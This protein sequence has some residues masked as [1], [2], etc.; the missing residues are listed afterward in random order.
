VLY[1]RPTACPDQQRRRYIDLL[2]PLEPRVLAAGDWRLA[3][4]LSH[5]LTHL[6]AFAT[7]SAGGLGAAVNG[8]AY[9]FQM[10]ASGGTYDPR[11]IT[12]NPI[13]GRSGRITVL[14][15]DNPGIALATGAKILFAGDGNALDIYDTRTHKRSSLNLKSSGGRAG[16]TVRSS[17]VF[18]TGDV[19]DASTGRLSST[20]SIEADGHMS[21]TAASVGNLALFAGGVE[22]DANSPAGVTETTLVDIYN[23][24]TGTWSSAQLS[25]ARFDI[26]ATSVGDL[27][28][29][30]GGVRGF[31]GE[32]DVVDIYNADSNSW[33]T[34]HL[35]QPREAAAA[36]TVGNLAIFAGGLSDLS[37][38]QLS[39]IVDVY[40]AATG[41]WFT[42]TLSAP[43]S[44]LA[45]TPVAGH[46]LFA[47]GSGPD[48][49]AV[50]IF[51]FVPG[52]TGSMS[53]KP[54]GAVNV[55][56]QSTGDAALPAGATVSLYASRDGTLAGATLLGTTTLPSGLDEQA[57]ISVS[58]QTSLT[59]VPKGRYHLIATA[60]DDTG[61]GP[62]VIVKQP[63]TF[64]VR[65]TATAHSHSA[66]RAHPFAVKAG[67]LHGWPV[68]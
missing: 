63:K 19:Y 14:S 51:T 17:A 47:D 55:T 62:V 5:T 39:D 33:S 68:T 7:G 48:P 40:D 35:S 56:V 23:A 15:H 66:S 25:Q 38:Q 11:A 43:R 41:Q 20:M 10:R 65:A 28:L 52:I 57:S 42:M 4:G 37:K 36:T 18:S 22:R 8:V 34:A 30:G 54:G 13:T 53:G 31:Q 27:A 64:T 9:F 2:E 67:P 49:T 16:T 21:S 3:T 6:H 44:G 61:Q 26:A 29:F 32:S 59:S 50:D 24:A 58:V 60:D 45:A 12:Y 1:K 46:A